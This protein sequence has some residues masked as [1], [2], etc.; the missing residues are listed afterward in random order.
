MFENYVRAEYAVAQ[1]ILIMISQLQQHKLNND[2]KRTT[3][4]VG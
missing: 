1:N 4:A 2:E 3:M